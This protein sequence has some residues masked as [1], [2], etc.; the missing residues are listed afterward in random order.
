M[1]LSQ[2]AELLTAIASYDRRKL[3]EADV[4][5]WQKLLTDVSLADGIEAV[6]RYYAEN[7]DWMMPA[8]LRRLVRDIVREREDAARA[9]GWAAGQAGVPKDQAMPEIA[10]PIAE[11]E[12]K[13]EIR[14]LLASVR[15]MLPEGSRDKL[16][17][18][19]VAWEKEHAAYRRTRSAQPN[20]AYRPNAYMDELERDACRANGPHD[21]GM[22]IESCPDANVSARPSGCICNH[23]GMSGGHADWCPLADQ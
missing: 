3:G 5:A 6:E 7:T 13:P 16:M 22:H 9:T 20:P 14:A 4:I 2:T 18:R 8:H 17:P 21:S 19:T 11:G 23:N 15:A 12:L 1:N 10:G